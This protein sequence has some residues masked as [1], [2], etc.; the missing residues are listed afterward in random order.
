MMLK[1]WSSIEEVPYFFHDHLSNFK[2][3]RDKKS[4]LLTQIERFLTVTPVW[5]HW[6]LW[7]D[8]QSLKQHRRGALLFF[9]VIRRISR[10]HGT[11]IADFDPN[12]AFPDCNS[13]LNSPMALKWW[14]KL[15][16]VWK[17]CP[18]VFQ[19]HPSNFKITRDKK[20]PILT[21]IVHFRTVTPVRI[22][23]WIWN[24]AQSLMQYRRGALLSFKVTHQISRSHGLKSWQ[25]ESNLSKITRPVAAIKSL[26]FALLF[27]PYFWYM[28]NTENDICILTFRGLLENI[29]SV[30]WKM[31]SLACRKR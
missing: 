29:F 31:F 1:V 15:S 25:F 23:Q 22:H 24:D 26:R 5:I 8:A 13:S 14:T 9:K 4:S 17:R 19:C 12:W 7:N 3:T 16:I 11:K 10:S 18:I 6:W 30:P 28:L 2:V 20:S 21:R 27:L